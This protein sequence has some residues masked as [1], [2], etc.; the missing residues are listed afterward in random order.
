MVDVRLTG[1]PALAVDELEIVEKGLY[2]SGVA[3]GLGV[4]VLFLFSF[5]SIRQSILA[6]IP[7]VVGIILTCLLCAT[8]VWPFELDY[9]KFYLRAL[10]VWGSIFPFTF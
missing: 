8:R 3:T 1:V 6:A 7:L 5:R 10:W 9:L 2:Q 4:L